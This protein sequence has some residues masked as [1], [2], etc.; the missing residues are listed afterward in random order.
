[1]KK[2][3]PR[4]TWDPAWGDMWEITCCGESCSMEK[5]TRYFCCGICAKV[6]ERP[7]EEADK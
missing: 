4:G 5:E 6:Y 2:S 3:Y 1:M 7:K